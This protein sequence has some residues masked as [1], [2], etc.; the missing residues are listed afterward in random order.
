MIE[1]NASLNDFTLI[2]ILIFE[3]LKN[4]FKT[5]HRANKKASCEQLAFQFRT[6]QVYSYILERIESLT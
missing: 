1:F 4:H 3:V 6:R 2:E 5:E